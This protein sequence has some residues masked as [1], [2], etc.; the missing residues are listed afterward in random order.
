MGESSAS[1]WSVPPAKN[2]VKVSQ[3]PA[4]RMGI[5]IVLAV[6]AIKGLALLAIVYVGARLAIRHEQVAV[7]RV[8]RSA[9]CGIDS[10]RMPPLCRLPVLSS[11]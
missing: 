6:R 11:C 9:I 2:N 4:P 5:I 7:R 8:P 1:N 3:Q 10:G